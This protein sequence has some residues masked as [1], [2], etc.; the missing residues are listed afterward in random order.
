M[1]ER[2]LTLN[3]I[4]TRRGANFKPHQIRTHKRSRHI[5]KIISKSDKLAQTKFIF[6]R[7]LFLINHY[8]FKFEIDKFR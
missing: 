1:M 8:Y 3:T 4:K 5:V 2:A 7:T 6:S